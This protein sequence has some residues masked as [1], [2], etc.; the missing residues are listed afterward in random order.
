MKLNE[1]KYTYILFSSNK[2]QAIE[3]LIYSSGYDYEYIKEYESGL[4][5]D[6]IICYIN[7]NNNKIREYALDIMNQLYLETLILKY[8]NSEYLS[9][10]YRD[11]TEMLLNIDYDLFENE[12]FVYNGCSF[13]FTEATLYKIPTLKEDFKVGMIIEFLN[14]NK[15]SEKKV[16][17]PDLEY[18]KMYKLLIKY[19]KIRI[20]L[21]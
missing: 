6:S 18:E 15:W 19:E 8:N 1:A 16:S 2:I 17:D 20:R 7:E 14:N 11:G 10:L 9:R 21:N 4:I 13:S 12:I 5:K 3:S